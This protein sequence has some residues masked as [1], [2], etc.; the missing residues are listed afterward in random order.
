[1]K[2][3]TDVLQQIMISITKT[4]PLKKIKNLQMIQQKPQRMIDR[5]QNFCNFQSTPHPQ[6]TLQFNVDEGESE[7]QK[8]LKYQDPKYFFGR[9]QFFLYELKWI[10]I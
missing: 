9:N 3:I 10:R 8:F 1:M 5:S 7:K 4:I 6:I 2:Q